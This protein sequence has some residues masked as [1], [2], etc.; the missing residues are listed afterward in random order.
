MACF[1]NCLYAAVL[2]PEV[3]VPYS[4]VVR[5]DV[6]QIQMHCCLPVLSLNGVGEFQH[7]QII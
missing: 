3:R 1:E 5:V 4:H 7:N 6:A 2:T